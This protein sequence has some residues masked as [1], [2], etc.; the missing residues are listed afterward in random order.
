M[1]HATLWFAEEKQKRNGLSALKVSERIKLKYGGVGPSECTIHRYVRDNLVGTSPLKKG[2]KGNIANFIYKTVA[3]AFESHV[4]INQL[5]G[6]GGENTRSKLRSRVNKVM[7][8]QEN[9]LSFK[10]LDRLIVE[11]AID[12]TAAKM[13]NV[14]QRRILWTTYKNLKMWFENWKVDLE[15]LGFA[16]RD[17]SGKLIISE[18]QLARIVNLDETCLSLDGS[19]GNRGGRP[20]VI[21]FDPRLPQVGAG[22]SKSSLMTT[23]VLCFILLQNMY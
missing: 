12:L 15:E 4:R 23:A 18:E 11:T 17:A 8:V 1:K 10:L 16:H 2:T 14:E 9:V 13:D 3:I 6:M 5:N 22:T 19:K 21:F 20:E 7:L